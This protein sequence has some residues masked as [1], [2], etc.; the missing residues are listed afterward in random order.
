ML[1]VQKF[2]NLQRKL[3]VHHALMVAAN[4]PWRI[5]IEISH[6]GILLLSIK[7]LLGHRFC[8][9]SCTSTSIT[10]LPFLLF[11]CSSLLLLLHFFLMRVMFKITK[12]RIEPN[13][14]APNRLKT[15]TSGFSKLAGRFGVL[16]KKTEPINSVHQ[17]PKTEPHREHP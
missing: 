8:H 10:G 2:L 3:S 15:I 16:K 4:N 12:N 9:F 7:L 13:W 6:F 5:K 11:Y 14:T 17:V 1:Y